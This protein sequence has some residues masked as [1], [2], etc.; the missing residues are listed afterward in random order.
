MNILYSKAKDWISTGSIGG[1]QI[2]ANNTIYYKIK[3]AFCV[4]NNSP[5]L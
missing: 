1:C 5:Y 4:I 2:L 3:E